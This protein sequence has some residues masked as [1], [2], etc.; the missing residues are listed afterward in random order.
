MDTETPQ[1]QKII[2]LESK[3]ETMQYRQPEWTRNTNTDSTGQ[4]RREKIPQEIYERYRNFITTKPTNIN[5]TIYFSKHRRD[6]HIGGAMSTKEFEKR[7]NAAQ[8]QRNKKM[9]S[10]QM[11]TIRENKV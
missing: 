7:E 4:N 2:S 6:P 11:I 9:T 8:Y 10:Q 5:K 1:E 3:I